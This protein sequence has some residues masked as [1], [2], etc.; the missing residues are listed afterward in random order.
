MA[1][2]IS[3]WRAR[4]NF[5]VR[6]STEAELF[7]SYFEKNIFTNY[8]Y[9]IFDFPYTCVYWLSFFQ[10]IAGPATLSTS[11]ATTKC[12]TDVTHANTQPL[13]SPG[14][15]V[16]SPQ[17][18]QQQQQHQPPQRQQQPT[19]HGQLKCRKKYNLVQKSTVCL[20]G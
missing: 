19:Q 2:I 5:W 14:P 16:L 12:T 1:L 3:S 6:A 17:Y 10:I 13:V 18:Q 11:S 9:L 7:S 20:K 15:P 4:S 8:S